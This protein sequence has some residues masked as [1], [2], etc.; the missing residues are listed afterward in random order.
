[1]CIVN[2][3]GPTLKPQRGDMCVAMNQKIGIESLLIIAYNKGQFI[4]N[5]IPTDIVTIHN[6]RFT[7]DADNKPTKRRRVETSG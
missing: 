2:I 3:V 4:N 7:R 1:M 6:K 5:T